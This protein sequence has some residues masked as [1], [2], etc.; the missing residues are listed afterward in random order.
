[1]S[2]PAPALARPRIGLIWAQSRGGVI[3][4]DG[5]MPWHVPED[6]AHFKRVTMGYPVIMGRKTWDALPARVRPLPGRHNI[7]LTRQAGWQAPGT[8]R[9]ADLAAALAA[10]AD[11]DWIWIIGGAQIFKLALPQADRLAITRI[12]ADFPGDTWA[13]PELAAYWQRNE[14]TRCTSQSG[15]QLQF[16][17]WDRAATGR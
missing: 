9:A 10:G 2:T 8:T 4:H 7:V 13:P 6:L 12:D 15:V 1:M 3:G 16:E 14:V 11:T 17:T 5:G